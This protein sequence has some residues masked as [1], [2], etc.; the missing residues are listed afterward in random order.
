MHWLLLCRCLALGPA[1]GEQPL[2]ADLAGPGFD[3]MALAA[4][5]NAELTAPALR[6]ALRRK[7]L[8]ERVPAD[9]HA[10]LTL[11][12]RQ[13]AARNARIRAQCA[14]AGGLLAAQGIKVVL[15]KGAAWLFDGHA[16][17]A[18][19]RMLRDI[20]L[21]VPRADLPCAVAILQAQG[22]RDST[23]TFAEREHFHHAPLIP[24]AGVGEAAIELHRDLGY[25]IHDL[26]AEAVLADAVAV[27]PGLCIPSTAHRALHNVL[28]AEIEN[29]GHIGAEVAIRDLLDLARLMQSDGV[30]TW[31]AEARS[32]RLRAALRGSL[33]LAGQLLA[34]PLPPGFEPGWRARLH[35]ARCLA[36]RRWPLLDRAGH[37]LALLRRGFR[38]ERDSYVPSD[39]AASQLD[40][41]GAVIGRL[42]RRLR[43]TAARD[44]R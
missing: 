14:A 1:R 40:R 24:E 22:Y 38:W 28:H 34:A 9:L 15:L 32:P 26:P 5:A 27:A 8:E 13:N 42:A 16:D 6:T 4:A 43:R 37:C 17:A 2:A 12:H 35:L 30:E 44:R 19:D 10:Y 20:D 3:A 7:G 25:G 31:A 11:L 36:H 23:E 18:E 39:V 29:A 33:L 41:R 21:L